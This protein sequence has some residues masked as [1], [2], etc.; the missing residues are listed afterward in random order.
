[1]DN[2]RTCDLISLGLILVFVGTAILGI[3]GKGPAYDEP[4]HV[5]AGISYWQT[6]SPRLNI[7]HPPLA[8]LVA[9][10]PSIFMDFPKIAE[11]MAG[12]WRQNASILEF[13]AAFIPYLDGKFL[14]WSRITM[15]LV[16]GGLMGGVLL[17]WSRQLFGSRYALLPMALF[18]FCP[19]LLA[20]APLAMTDFAVASLYFASVHAWWRYLRKPGHIG[21]AWVCVTVG[22]AFSSKNSSLVLC[23][24]FLLSGMA[25][26][27]L[28]GIYGI[29]VETRKRME[30]VVYGLGIITVSTIVFINASYLFSGSFLPPQEFREYATSI[31]D[32]KIRSVAYSIANRWPE[33][34]PIPLPFHFV[35]GLINRI[36]HIQSFRSYF[37]GIYLG[38]GGWPNYFPVLLL[39]KLTLP[40]WALVVPGMAKA[41]GKFSKGMFDTIFLG[42]PPSI[43]LLVASITPVNIGIRHVLP[44]IPFLLVFSGY[45]CL[46]GTRAGFTAILACVLVNACQSIRIHP[47]YLV[48]FNFLGGGPE[49]GWGVSNYDDLGQDSTGLAQWLQ[50]RNIDHVAYGAFGWGN[51]VLQRA[52]IR[53]EAIPCE[54]T[55]QLVAIHVSRLLMEYESAACYLWMKL[56][57]PDEKIGYTIFLYNSKTP[58]QTKPSRDATE[59]L[60]TGLSLYRLGKF[61]ESIAATRQAL[62]IKP[63]Y[64]LAYN[65]IC[66]AYNSLH[67]WQ[68]AIHACT[69]AK[70]L[71]PGLELARNNLAWAEK[72]LVDT[73]DSYG[74]SESTK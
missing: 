15:A 32:L 40:M 22:A 16:F 19:T 21:L 36:V 38:S 72:N 66:A 29:A 54:N 52:G 74:I 18:A 12:E 10:I 2:S 34:L 4:Y 42:V 55:G 46:S 44:V 13:P 71:D 62:R 65:N 47:H 51:P 37:M 25:Y 53:T 31:G 45:I 28:D 26:I 57:E 24:V 30:I 27:L 68:E 6:G 33:W 61:E 48:Y 7:D 43:Y 56:R 63:D 69:Q 1:M 14:L 67:Q 5:I 41:F 8:R 39:F 20:H 60:N 49:R 11:V 70:K 50:E 35:A 64:A 23:P 9:G 17:T 59:Y 3:I 58:A 73:R